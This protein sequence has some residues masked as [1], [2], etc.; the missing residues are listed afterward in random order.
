MP[1]ACSTSNEL[2]VA[3]VICPPAPLRSIVG[4]MIRSS[5]TAPS[6]F[7][8]GH[9]TAPTWQEAVR[10]VA[11]QLG[12]RD[13]DDMG[14]VYV[15]D[16]VAGNLRDIVAFLAAATGLDNWCGTVGIGVC[17]SSAE[18]FDKPAI[19]AMACRLANTGSAFFRNV[20]EAITAWRDL[21]TGQPGA[22]GIVHGDPRFAELTAEVPRLARDT[23]SFLVGGL[24]S[25]RGDF[26][27][28]AGQ[29]TH[30]N[31]SG[32]LLT[33]AN[34]AT[35]LTQGC[36]LLEGCHEVTDAEDHNILELDRKPALDVLQKVFTDAMAEGRR[37]DPQALHVALPVPGS[38]T[39]AFLVRNLVGVDPESR[40]ITIGERVRP[41]DALMFC[42]R[43]R[44]AAEADL[45]RMLEDLKTRVPRPLGG[46]YFSCLARG[47]NMFGAENREMEIIAEILGDVPMAGFFG[48]G[49]I[50]FDRLYAYTGVL[51]LFRDA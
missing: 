33:G 38:D 48:N 16:H 9:A 17:S 11:A 5:Q 49:E 28:F 46:L 7:A 40:S 50:S 8:C 12:D 27:A 3:R 32:V 35:A 21:A 31:L 24:T 22:F 37:I 51:T 2:P 39:G 26:A 47:A 4:P 34:V 10:S 45:R 29:P 13:D 19:V 14:F 25:S 20:D 41:G 1:G 18:Y 36:S 15:T 23:E 30:G 42:V 6:V 44:D 43:D